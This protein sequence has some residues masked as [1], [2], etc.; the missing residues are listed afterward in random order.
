MHSRLTF[1]NVAS[2]TALFISLGGGAYAATNDSAPADGT[3]RACV[4]KDGSVRVVT[5]KG[6]CKK[7]ETAIAWN[8]QGPVGEAGLPGERGPAGAD[9]APGKDGKDVD[10]GNHFT[11][12]ESDARYLPVAGKA[13]DAEK[14]DGADSADFARAGDLLFARVAS[15][16]ATVSGSRPAGVTAT[17]LGINASR[18]TFGRDVA[19]CSFTAIEADGSPSG[20]TIAVAAAG[21]GDVDV[22]FQTTRHAFHLQVIC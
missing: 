13:A 2:A 14:L 17:P 3:I 18:V 5:A 7:R 9:G 22:V 4:A 6:P 12:P 11:K 10:A 15:N 1:A 19:A 20:E 8:R 21:G 16:G